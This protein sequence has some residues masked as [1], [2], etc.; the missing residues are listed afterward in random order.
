MSTNDQ[1]LFEIACSF[2]A[3]RFKGVDKGNI[4]GITPTDFY[5]LD[6]SNYLYEGG[7]GVLSHGEFLI[8]EALLNLCNPDIHKLFNLGEALQILDPDNM[9]ALCNAI[10]RTYNRR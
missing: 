1:R 7:G 10:V 5:D 4:P 9:Q 6:L 8:L 2:P 3:L